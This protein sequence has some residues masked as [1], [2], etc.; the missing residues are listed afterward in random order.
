VLPAFG[1]I[2]ISTIVTA[3]AIGAIVLWRRRSL[4]LAL[5]AVMAWASS[6]EIAFNA[7]GAV[8]H[9][10]SATYAAW[11]AAAL[12]GWIMVA[13]YRHVRPHRW[14]ALAAVMVVAVWIATGFEANSLSLSGAGY[15]ASFSPLAELFNET[16]KT[17][18]GAAFLVGALR[19]P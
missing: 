11:L 16:S 15:T 2:R 12:A 14:L 18:L 8:V 13:W 5:I 1:P 3:L 4:L 10:W 9:G 6:Y 17:L 7:I 19:A